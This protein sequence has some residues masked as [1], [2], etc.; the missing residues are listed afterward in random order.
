MKPVLIQTLLQHRK[1]R[2][3]RELDNGT[4][5]HAHGGHKDRSG[6]IV[7]MIL[8]VAVIVALFLE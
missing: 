1:N 8:M 5:D 2:K 7:V 3:P 4:V 6:F